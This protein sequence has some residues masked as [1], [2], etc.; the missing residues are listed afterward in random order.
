M[1]D[2]IFTT[3]P[4]VFSWVRCIRVISFPTTTECLHIAVKMLSIA[5][6]NKQ[7]TNNKNVVLDSVILISHIF[8]FIVE[9]FKAG[10]SDDP[11]LI[12]RTKP[13]AGDVLDGNVI[14]TDKKYQSENDRI[15]ASWKGFYDPE[16]GIDE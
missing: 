2:P 1:G 13:F 15:C 10:H 12:D 8:T 7:T 4:R 3:L 11:I 9:L 6:N 14:E 16:S 5:E